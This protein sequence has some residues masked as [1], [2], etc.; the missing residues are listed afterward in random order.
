MHLFSFDY[1]PND[2]GIARLCAAIARGY[3]ASVLSQQTPPGS[4][5]PDIDALVPT[6]RVRRARPWREIEALRHLR[7]LPKEAVCLSAIWYPEGLVAMLAGV[8]PH[9]ILAHGAELFPPAQPWRR[10]VWRWLRRRVLESAGLVVANSHYTAEMVRA[11]APAARVV[12]IPL[13]VDHERFSPADRTAVRQKWGIGDH[14]VVCSVSRIH[15]YKGY[16][17]VLKALAALSPHERTQITYL[18]AGK[19]PDLELLKRRAREL[20]VDQQVRWL[21]FV[22]DDDL[23]DLYRAADLFVLAT[24]ERPGE[25]SVEGFGLV[26]LE[27]QAC[28]TP[29]VGTRTGGIPDAITDGDGGWLIEQDDVSALAGIFRRLVGEPDTFT[30]MGRLARRRVEREFTWEHYLMRLH[31]ALHNAGIEPGARHA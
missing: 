13:A 11:L 12:A 27:A 2:G 7:R 26:F 5:A 24:Q 17:T 8:K 10:G 19:G 18:I 31:D 30:D 1:P 14:R 20:G 23:P 4:V 22:P 3:A 21:G 28:G 16:E 15:A 29:V 6:T 9:V 25:Q